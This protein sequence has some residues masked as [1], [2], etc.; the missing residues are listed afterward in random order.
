MNVSCVWHIL[1]PLQYIQ[2][3]S[4]IYTPINKREMRSFCRPMALLMRTTSGAVHQPVN[5]LPSGWPS[6]SPL[7]GISHLNNPLPPSAPHPL[8]PVLCLLCPCPSLVCSFPVL[9]HVSWLWL[10]QGA[11]IP[12]LVNLFPPLPPCS[13]CYSQVHPEWPWHLWNCLC[14]R[15]LILLGCLF[16]Y[17]DA[18]GEMGSLLYL[19]HHLHSSALSSL[20]H[21]LV[22]WQDKTSKHGLGTRI[23]AQICEFLGA[24]LVTQ[25]FIR[26]H[27]PIF[28]RSDLR[29]QHVCGCC[30]TVESCPLFRLQTCDSTLQ[31]WW[32]NRLIHWLINSL[33]PLNCL[34]GGCRIVWHCSSPL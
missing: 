20:S 34:L 1:L 13:P 23:S 4:V 3:D 30:L 2:R 33:L 15:V 17:W 28:H 26:V 31:E 11:V 21:L 10:V 16:N 18:D 8:R 6:T 19:L 27:L 32:I 22:P 24:C 9:D 29:W 14:F 7:Y 25:T 5:R 12:S